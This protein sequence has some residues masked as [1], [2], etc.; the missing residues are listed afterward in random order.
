MR[1]LPM[2]AQTHTAQFAQ[3]ILTQNIHGRKFDYVRLI[4][5]TAPFCVT[6]CNPINA[7]ILRT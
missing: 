6:L 1:N 3:H 2:H 7:F 5:S 4:S